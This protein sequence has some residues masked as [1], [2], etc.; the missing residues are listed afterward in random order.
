MDLIY[1]YVSLGDDEANDPR[2]YI[3][4]LGAKAVKRARLRSAL[5]T[6]NFLWEKHMG[7]GGAIGCYMYVHTMKMYVQCLYCTRGRPG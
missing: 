1:K 6:T 7:G 2:E 5:A 4:F 3:F